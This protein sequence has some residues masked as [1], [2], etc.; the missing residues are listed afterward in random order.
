[1]R[2]ITE[3]ALVRWLE[4]SPRKERMIKSRSD[5]TIIVDNYD[6][7]KGY[8]KMIE[9]IDGLGLHFR[10]IPPD[11]IEISTKKMEQSFIDHRK[12]CYENLKLLAERAEILMSPLNK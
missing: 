3:S 9:D 4:E 5:T 1:M 10:C 8:G 7:E 11:P 12:A 2:A 6:L